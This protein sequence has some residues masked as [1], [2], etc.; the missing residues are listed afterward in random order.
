MCSNT[1]FNDHLS[2]SCCKYS[3]TN[4]ETTSLI[5]RCCAEEKSTTT[6]TVDNISSCLSLGL[7]SQT[8]LFSSKESDIVDQYLLSLVEQNKNLMILKNHNI[9]IRR[10]HESLDQV[11]ILSGGSAGHEPL[12]TGFVGEGMLTAAVVGNINVCPSHQ[13][14]LHAIREL[15]VNNDNGI[16]VICMNYAADRL[17]F[18]LAVQ[19]AAREGIRVLCL[20]VGDDCSSIISDKLAGRR[21][22]AGIVLMQKIASAMAAA[23]KTLYEIFYV[24]QALSGKHLGTINV[25]LPNSCDKMEVGIGLKGEQGITKSNVTDMTTVIHN[26]IWYVLNIASYF[27][28]NVKQGDSIV[29]LVNNFH[30]LTDLELNITILDILNVLF[31]YGLNIQRIY[32]GNYL[33]CKICY[34]FS[35]TILKIDNPNIIKWLDYPVQVS[36]WENKVTKFE[37]GNK[38][39]INF[40]VTASYPRLNDPVIQLG[41]KFT[42]KEANKLIGMLSLVMNAIISAEDYLN[43]I[44]FDH[45]CGTT[46]KNFAIEILDAI[47][48]GRVVTETPYGLFNYLSTIAASKMAGMST[49]VYFILC[50]AAAQVT[51]YSNYKLIF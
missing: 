2:D 35:I 31:H 43:S 45:D 22:L 20:V 4:I 19:M 12:H 30:M 26:A 33:T 51:N 39:K 38:G 44:D 3:E 27:A 5:D 41:P 32:A 36:G 37:S 49:S 15:S 46:M 10:D 14:I 50:S 18:G 11:K 40:Y 23:K 28:L 34:G 8:N 9:L 21:G 24:C 25:G 17:N 47:E 29:L 7:C 42:F 48:Y 6:T 13:S 1:V 16:I